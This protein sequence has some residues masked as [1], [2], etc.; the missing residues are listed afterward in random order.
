MGSVFDSESR[1]QPFGWFAPYGHGFNPNPDLAPLRSHPRWWDAR[2]EDALRESIRHWQW[3]WL[4]GFG[5]WFV[6]NV[7]ASHQTQAMDYAAAKAKQLGLLEGVRLPAIGK[8]CLQCGQLFRE[9]G[10]AGSC[11]SRFGNVESIDF[12]NPCMVGVLNQPTREDDHAAPTD[13]AA[14][15]EK[16]Q[17]I[18][19][20]QDVA[21]VLQR[22]PSQSFPSIEEFREADRTERRQVVTL[23]QRRPSAMRVKELFGSWLAALI[24]SDLLENGTRRLLLGTQCVARDGHVCFSLGEKTIDDLLTEMGVDHEREPHYP[25]GN[26]RA[27]FRIGETLVEFL[28]LKGQPDYDEKTTLKTKLCESI[29]IKL[30]LIEPNDLAS[31]TKLIEKIKKV[32]AP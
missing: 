32:L 12:C 1:M 29:G 23:C 20:L 15:F 2:A 24:A 27:D 31:R 13:A 8:P 21:K 22:I 7:R 26:L 9:D 19:W 6:E 18:G 14:P 17:I 30:L 25:H 4:Y 5:T 11:L 10:V 16:E 3:A 28:G